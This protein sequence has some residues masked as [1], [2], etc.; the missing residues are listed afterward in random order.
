[1]NP[2]KTNSPSQASEPPV[3]QA[4]RT[5]EPARTT[6]AAK[7]QAPVLRF[8]PT[9]WAKLLYFRDRGHT[10][11]GGFGITPIDDLLCVKQFLT[12]RQEA[13]AVSI[14]FDDDAVADLFDA[15]VDAGRKPEQ[16]A[17]IWCHSHPGDSPEPS[18]VDEE[19][20][21]RVFGGCQWAVMFVVGKTG[22][23]HARMRFNVGPGGEV[24]I[25]VQ[26]DYRPPFAGS[27]AETW[28]AEYKANIRPRT[29]RLASRLD[30]L[31]LADEPEQYDEP[32]GADLC[33]DDVTR[34]EIVDMDPAEREFI[35]AEMGLDPSAWQSGSEVP[36]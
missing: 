27:D 6:R 29:P 5:S 11:I 17:R 13:T 28:E 30:S 31:A 4:Q 14:A 22:R 33:V 9:A 3:G 24:M 35:L 19:T 25:P 8:S 18:C 1:M 12:V 15:Q 36:V 10:E 23:T 21:R 26:V 34:A 7:P 16:F 2:K 32:F 20:F